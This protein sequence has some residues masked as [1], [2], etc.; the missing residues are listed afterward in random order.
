[1]ELFHDAQT[2]RPFGSEIEVCRALASVSYTQSKTRFIIDLLLGSGC[3]KIV[4]WWELLRHR[5][6][7]ISRPSRSRVSL[8]PRTRRRWSCRRASPPTRWTPSGRSA[9]KA[10][11]TSSPSR[12]RSDRS[13]SSRRFKSAGMAPKSNQKNVF[14]CVCD[15]ELFNFFWETVAVSPCRFL[16]ILSEEVLPA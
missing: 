9:D 6:S 13:K 4:D 8:R 1:M 2:D 7:L 12:G 16:K 5:R 3:V 15:P 14:F 11:S 10:V